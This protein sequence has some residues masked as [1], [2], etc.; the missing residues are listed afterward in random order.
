MNQ[1]FH[2]IATTIIAHRV[3]QSWAQWHK[4]IIL[5]FGGLRQED[6]EFEANLGC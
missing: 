4:P 3:S 1:I 6:E 2:Y 5:V